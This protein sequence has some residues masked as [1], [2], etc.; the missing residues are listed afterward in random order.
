MKKILIAILT[1]ILATSAV[2]AAL[3]DDL[4]SYWKFDGTSGGVTDIHGNNDG[5]NNGALRGV[6]GKLNRAFDFD[7]SGNSIEINSGDLGYD[8]VTVSAWINP[9]SLNSYS[10]ILDGERGMRSFI[11]R[12]DGN[13]LEF[14]VQV[15]GGWHHVQT[16][17]SATNQWSHVVGVYDGSEYQIW[18]NG[19]NRGTGSLSGHL[20]AFDIR[21]IGGDSDDQRYF[22]G[23]IDEVGVWGRGLNQTEIETLY[24]NGNGLN[25]DSIINSISNELPQIGTFKPSDGETNVS[26]SPLLNVTVSDS[27]DSILD[28]S[29]YEGQLWNLSYVNYDLISFSPEG[30]SV[31]DL[32]FSSDGK[33]IFVINRY[34]GITQHSCTDAW[35]LSSCNYDGISISTEGSASGI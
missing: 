9:D 13:N 31:R 1:I 21:W 26:T 10:Y 16:L 25:Y 35:N 27:D 34:D 33:R 28:V 2:S 6:S 24:N 29:F 17:F 7:G 22:D 20:D 30:N 14:Y 8:Y 23:T 19:Q 3:K 32:S 12:H 18:I 4:V 15:G 11:F 5:T